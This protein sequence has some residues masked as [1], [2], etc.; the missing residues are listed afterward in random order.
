[1]RDIAL[2]LFFIACLVP[3]LKHPWLGVIMWV[4][5]SVMSPHRLTYNFAYDMQFAAVTVAVTIIG[6]LATKDE[7]RLPIAGPVVFMAMFSLWM[8]LTTAMAIHGDADTWA[9]W[10]RVM[11]IMMMNFVALILIHDRKQIQWVVYAIVISLGFYGV[12]GGLFTAVTGGHYIVW[13]PDGS[14]IYDNNGLAL[15]LVVVIPL[16]R[17]VQLQLAKKWQK[18]GLSIAMV[19]C[20]LAAIGSQSRGALLALAA[21]GAV[22]WW[23]SRNKAVLAMALVLLGIAG[24]AFMPESWFARMHTIE[25]YDEDASALGRINAWWMCFNLAKDHFFGGGYSIYEPDLFARYAPNPLDI[26]AAHSIYFQALGEH[27][28]IGLFLYMGIGASTWLLAGRTRK[29]AKNVPDLVWAVQLMDMVKVSQIGFAVGGAFLSLAYFDVP[30]YIAVIVVATHEFVRRSS[31]VMK[32]TG[33]A[34]D[35]RRADRFRRSHALLGPDPTEQPAPQ[36]AL[37]RARPVWGE[38]T[39]R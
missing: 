25:T 13:G 20:A 3:M 7:R 11:K 35:W 16:M 31:Q 33:D 24:L 18:R 4:W 6:M 14:F 36:P 17:Y 8:C 5:L 30:Y 37:Y 23:K 39:G 9:M 19:L 26:H 1:M 29:L 38:R 12:K 34:L 22:F 15:A 32:A 27:G 28:F 21:M 2:L 10:S